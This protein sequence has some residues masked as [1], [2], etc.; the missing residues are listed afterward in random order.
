MFDS[1]GDHPGLLFVAATLLPMAAFLVLLLAGGLRWF[2]WSRCKEGG[3]G[4]QVFQMLGGSVT[5][6]G[7]A[8][9][10]T[11]AIGLACVCCVFGLVLFLSEH[12]VMHGQVEANKK[13][14]AQL[15]AQ[16]TAKKQADADEHKETPKKKDD[17][18]DDKDHKSEHGAA[19][20]AASHEK[21][22]ELV[23]SNELLEQKFEL[24]WIGRASCRERVYVLV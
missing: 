5:G 20:H 9:V 12:H 7:P 3:V 21:I 4:D 11:A 8:W 2:L 19:G 6:R 22:E 18:K 14:I 16:Q 10:A 15:E 13:A 1:L 17:H 24:R 23:E